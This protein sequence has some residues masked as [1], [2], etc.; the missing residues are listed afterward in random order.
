VPTTRES[1]DQ[2]LAAIHAADEYYKSGTSLEAKRETIDWARRA[3]IDAVDALL[4]DGEYWDQLGREVRGLSP[5]PESIRL[6]KDLLSRQLAV[7][8]AGSGYRG[9]PPAVVL[10][11]QANA[12]VD[13]V[14]TSPPPGRAE[15]ISAAQSALRGLRRG[16][17]Q[18]SVETRRSIRLLRKAGAALA[19]AALGFGQ[20]FAPAAG[21]AALDL[22]K[23]AVLDLIVTVA[24]E[25][26]EAEP[27]HPQDDLAYSRVK[28]QLA[29]QRK[30][31]AEADLAELRLRRAQ[32]R[33][34]EPSV[35]FT[36]KARS[37]DG[38]A[39]ALSEAPGDNPDAPPDR[40]AKETRPQA[41]REDSQ[42]AD[43]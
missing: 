30:A 19:A 10:V 32:S 38:P 22:G 27:Q 33:A 6:T 24:H 5:T 36:P 31:E 29:R 42:D 12:A 41:R 17:E 34:Q 15:A 25:P 23:E 18:R 4:D 28:T 43:W 1:L 20:W 35:T 16:L 13:R 3:A 14:S 37:D 26:D 40:T 9:P 7:I 21:E 39:G 2:A 11:R 8:L